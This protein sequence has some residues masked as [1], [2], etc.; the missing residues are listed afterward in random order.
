MNGYVDLPDSIDT[1]V[2]FLNKIMLPAI[3]KIRMTSQISVLSCK[4]NHG[5]EAP[6]FEK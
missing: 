3:K 5:I 4:V 1:L 6:L 2:N